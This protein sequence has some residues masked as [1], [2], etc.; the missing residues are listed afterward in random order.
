MGMGKGPAEGVTY[1]NNWALVTALATPHET[2]QCAADRAAPTR[3][4][5]ASY[6][7]ESRLQGPEPNW[8][9]RKSSAEHGQI[10]HEHHHLHLLH[11]G[12]GDSPEF[13]HGRD[14]DQEDG[15][16]PAADL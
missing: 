4:V 2:C 5:E 1:S 14:A 15:D 6:S 13:V 16:E 10:L 11:H 12:I 7:P 8:R 3:G 9:D